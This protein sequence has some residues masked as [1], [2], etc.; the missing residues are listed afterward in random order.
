MLIHLHKLSRFCGLKHT[1]LPNVLR[2]GSA[3]AGKGYAAEDCLEVVQRGF[4]EGSTPSWTNGGVPEG[5]PSVT[6]GV[7]TPSLVDDVPTHLYDQPPGGATRGELSTIFVDTFNHMHPG[8]R[9]YPNQEPLPGTY[10]CRFCGLDFITAIP[11]GI[12]AAA[13]SQLC[14]AERWAQAVPDRL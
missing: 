7:T 5:R 1:M 6:Q 10:Q 12:K 11:D 4:P 13:H 14:E 8:D 2:R 3:Y 9:F